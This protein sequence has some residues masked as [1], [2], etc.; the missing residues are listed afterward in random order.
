MSRPLREPFFLP[1]QSRWIRDNSPLKLLEKS[2]QVGMS[3][4]S[5]YRLVRLHALRGRRLDSWVS[6][7]DELQAKLFIGDCR[8]FGTLLD[9]VGHLLGKKALAKEIRTS[10][11]S[12]PFANGSAIHSLSS[13]SDAQA[14]KRGSRV[15]DEF[16]LHCDPKLLYAIALPGITW[17]GQLEILSTHRGAG[18]FFNGLV[19]EARCGGNPKNFSLHRVTLQD[20]LEQGFLKKLKGKLPPTDPRQFLDEAQYFDYVRRSCPDE[21]TFRQ[22]YMCQPEDEADAFLPYELI[23]SC[24]MAEGEKWAGPTEELA[25]DGPAYLGVDLGRSRDLSVFWLLERRGTICWTRRVECLRGKTFTEQERLLD[26]FLRLPRLV[27]AC[28]DCTGM[29]QQFTERA[30]ERFGKFRVEGIVFTA[31]AKESLAL[32]LRAAFER[33]ELRIPPDRAV[34]A[35]LHSIR[36]ESTLSG[37]LRLAADRTG[38]GHGDRFWALAL[39][40]HG[41]V[42]GRPGRESAIQTLSCGRRPFPLT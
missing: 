28:V 9:G 14:G 23:E 41:A 3:W 30:V 18:N 22:E 25:L 12:L 6:S 37:H 38:A 8:A 4:A 42:H 29:G 27:R 15:L 35:D 11:L 34:R 1:Y 40:I 2:R 26:Y 19:Q 36:R 24:E 39:A 7:R 5:A 20:A 16:A 13:S 33:K 17:G 10:S 32:G 21:A 31:A